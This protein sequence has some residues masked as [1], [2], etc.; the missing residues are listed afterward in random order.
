MFAVACLIFGC[1]LGW[2]RATRRGGQTADKV[3]YA[4]AHGFAF[5]LA[6]FAIGIAAHYLFFD[7]A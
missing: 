6:A 1:I 7:G 2:V 5:G 3:Q 4:I